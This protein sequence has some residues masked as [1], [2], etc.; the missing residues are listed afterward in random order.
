MFSFPRTVVS[1]R[2]NK[3]TC[4]SKEL[5]NVL[6]KKVPSNLPETSL[7]CVAPAITIVTFTG[8][9]ILEDEEIQLYKNQLANEKLSFETVGK[10]TYLTWWVISDV[11]REQIE[12]C[13]IMPKMVCGACL[14]K[15]SDT[16]L[17]KKTVAIRSC[18]KCDLGI[19]E[20]AKH[21]VMQCPYFKEDWKLMLDEMTDLGCDEING[22]LNELENLFWCLMGKHPT[23]IEFG[24][25]YSFWTIAASHISKIYERTIL[26]R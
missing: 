21:M 18:D 13:E 2:Q 10:P 22:I 1:S 16:K 12:K 4:I 15:A 5:N 23:D 24:V 6:S 19:E 7:I 3:D 17:K 26:G 8:A 14:L 25:M 11:S 9:T 20:T